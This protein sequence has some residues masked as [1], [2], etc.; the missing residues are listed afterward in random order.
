MGKEAMQHSGRKVHHG[1]FENLN[2]PTRFHG[3]FCLA[4]LY[5][6]PR[7]KL[8][9]CLRNLSRHLVHGGVMLITIPSGPPYLDCQLEDGKWVNFMGTNMLINHINAAGSLALLHVD[10]N[11]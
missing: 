4:S 5:H 7:A 2:L 1:D 9:A 6:V 8:T 11:F 3:I 10:E